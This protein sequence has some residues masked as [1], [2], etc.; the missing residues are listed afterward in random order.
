MVV[1]THRTVSLMV[2]VHNDVLCLA[3]G[4][5]NN[6]VESVSITMNSTKLVL[7]RAWPRDGGGARSLP[8]SPPPAQSASPPFSGPKLRFHTSLL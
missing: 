5:E 3:V 1:A 8:A 2:T 6:H 7:R 4:G